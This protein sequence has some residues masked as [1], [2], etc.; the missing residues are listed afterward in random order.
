MIAV[1]HNLDSVVSVFK[2][3]GFTIKPGRLHSNNLINAHVKFSNETEVELMSIQGKPTD[4][5]AEDYKELLDQMQGGAYIAL[6]GGTA[7]NFSN[8]LSK[9]NIGHT[10]E[11]HPSW[12]YVIFPKSSVLCSF[13]FIE[14][15]IAANDA[16]DIFIHSNGS[17]MINEVWVEGSPQTVKML[18]SIGLSLTENNHGSMLAPSERFQ[19]STGSIILM[20]IETQGR[21][22]RVRSISF[23]DAI[24]RETY[25]IDD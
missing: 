16:S 24:G 4:E 2:S 18:K 1:Y 13:F 23:R 14:S 22:P 6:S 25:K 15:H 12:S 20:P 3:Q 9:Q 17:T 10:L 8:L 7:R 11:E 5:S 19:T 21:R